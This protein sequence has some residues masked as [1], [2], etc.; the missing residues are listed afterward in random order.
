MNSNYIISVYLRK[1]SLAVLVR[2]AKLFPDKAFLRFRYYLERG[3]T[4]NI[5]NPKTFN[6]KIN[7]LKLYNRKPEY[8]TMVDKYAVK[9]FVSERIGQ[10]YIIPTIGIWNTPEEIEF[11]TL[12]NQFVL[13]TTH[14]GGSS[15]VVICNDSVSFDRASAI[16]KLQESMKTD[17]FT[18][19]R[20][21]PYKNVPRKIIAE[22][23]MTEG[24]SFGLTDYKFFC[25]NGEPRLSQV[26]SDR[27]TEEKIDFFDMQWERIESL[28]GLNPKV[29][30]S[31]SI[32]SR[33]H[34]FEEMK[35]IAKTLSQGTPFSR[36]DLYEVNGHCYFGEITF[37]P[38]GGMGY[39][40][41]EEWNEK[42]GSWIIL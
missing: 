31:G 20:E 3:E 26:I 39:F 29:N 1:I 12:P 19:Y 5:D 35:Q 7:W 21:W 23:Y 40:R 38:A 16:R 4:L 14:G 22:P 34:S 9:D 25:F 8:T 18:G 6:E 30:N 37:F 42:I 27:K 11:D 36:I 17:I 10:K 32:I 15:G 33:P 28:V 13:K 41:P 2:F 24:D